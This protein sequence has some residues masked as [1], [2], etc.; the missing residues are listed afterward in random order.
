MADMMIEVRESIRSKI[1]ADSDSYQSI[2]KDE[3]YYYAAGQLAA[4]FLSKSRTKKRNHSS[5]NVFLNCK[6]DELL[7]EKMKILFV[8]YNYDIDEKFKRFN[9]L[10]NMVLSYQ[11][12]G[13]VLQTYMTA[14]YISC[15]LIYEKGDNKDE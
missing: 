9:H 7:K 14:G 13:D 5:F 8:K 1:N 4:F 10:Y 12:S 15:N 3:E 2:D 6:N 11:P